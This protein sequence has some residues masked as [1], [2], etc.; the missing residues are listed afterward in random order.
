VEAA[1]IRSPAVSRLRRLGPGLSDAQLVA[2]VREGDE[3]AFELVFDRYH[4]QLLSF[5]R[6]M[7]GGR[8]EAEDALQQVFVSAHGHL[9][10][11][12]RPVELR[13]WLYAIARNRC[14]SVLRGRR[15]ALGLD[16]VP[17]PSTAGLVV[18]AEVERRED[19]RELLADLARL[20]DE[21]RAAL[22]L[23]ELDAF[24]H[25]EIADV[26]GV[27]R[28]K[29]KALVFQA[30]E[31]LG[32]WRQARHTDCS[33]I[34]EQLA[35]LRGGAL[36]RGPLRRHLET[37]EACRDFR[38]EVRRQREAMALLLPVLPSLAFKAKV[39]GAVAS[40]HGATQAAAGAGGLFGGGLTA[41]AAGPAGGA[42]AAALGG[43]LAAKAAVLVA[44]AGIAGG[45]YAVTRHTSTAPSA[46]RTHPSS[47][48]AARHQS[49]PASGST[50]S[51]AAGAGRSHTAAHRAGRSSS[52]PGH[53][54]VRPAATSTHGKAY[55]NP[56]AS[57]HAHG[58]TGHGTKAQGNAV[59][60]TH[61]A[62]SPAARPRPAKPAHP[63]KPSHPASANTPAAATDTTTTS[64]GGSADSGRHLGSQQDLPGLRLPAVG[65]TRKGAGA[66]G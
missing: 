50:V 9:V 6:H 19:L 58:A 65:G 39:V 15:E 47:V 34:R 35:N 33:E 7:L 18:A 30:R 49:A 25:D 1:S 2:R 32:G 37:C 17:E 11:H 27:R 53:T 41:G 61:G 20:P 23:S 52:A 66:A 21:Q 29:V 44:V 62:K 38:V 31:S 56:V 24:S 63:A 14:L 16:E 54:G 46:F 12:D 10:A 51:P 22:L 64:S 40:A 5:C 43:G 3:R 57:A 48:P 45:G 42:S 8:E 28:D 55:T 13:P 4:P 60:P 36:R 59:T 26:L